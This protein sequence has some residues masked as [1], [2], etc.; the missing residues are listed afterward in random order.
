MWC[1]WKTGMAGL[2]RSAHCLLGVLTLAILVGGGCSSNRA[3][4]LDPPAGTSESMP[5]TVEE[6]PVP[7]PIEVEP[8][9]PPPPASAPE[10]VV[11][12]PEPVVEIPEPEPEPEDDTLV[13]IDTGAKDLT[14]RPTSLAEA[15]QVERE[16]RQVAEPTNI[17][18]TD[19]NL[20]E[21]ATGDLT[22]ADR[23]EAADGERAAM[24]QFE[25]ETAEKEAY[26]R[27]GAREIRQQWR[28]AYDKIPVLE[29]KVFELRQAFYRE[30]NGFYRDGEIKP[31]WD[32][33]IE[34]LEEARLEVEA[35]QGELAQFLETGREAG[36][37]PGWL[38]EGLDLEPII[39]EAVEPTAEPSEPVIYNQEATDPP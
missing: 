10:P 13:T 6:S 7:E 25:K 17:V 28:N 26:W 31:A 19:K 2:E 32:R 4:P 1:A 38:R 8:S 5:V 23:P 15:A 21:Y 37:L 9:P 34:Q 29:E 33:A 20:A 18:I 3:L 12:A 16:R 11:E 14:E 24:L 39:E 30:D 22:T 36:A 35:R 27:E